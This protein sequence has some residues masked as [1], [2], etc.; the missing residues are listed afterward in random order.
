GVGTVSLRRWLPERAWVAAPAAVALLAL[1]APAAALRDPRDLGLLPTETPGEVRAGPADLLVPYAIPFLADLGEVREAL[2][3]P[4]GPGD[5]IL[6][7][8]EHADEPIG[9]LLVALP[10]EGRWTVVRREGPFDKGGA[11]FAAADQYGRANHPPELDWWYELVERGL[12]DALA[13]SGSRCPS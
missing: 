4:Q 11:L 13:E 7:T 9:A 3:I 8:L 6:E 12:C 2:A 10:G 1:G 5:E